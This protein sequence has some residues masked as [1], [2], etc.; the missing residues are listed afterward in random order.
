[1][2]DEFDAYTAEIRHIE[3]E[4]FAGCPAAERL[5]NES[6]WDQNRGRLEQVRE[7]HGIR[8]DDPRI[9]AVYY[10]RRELAAVD[11]EAM[12]AAR[13]ERANPA[14]TP[15]ELE[16]FDHNRARLRRRVADV[17]ARFFGQINLLDLGT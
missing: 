7:A 12:E 14:P 13:A 3:D 5:S 6:P 4:W 16:A 11:A 1:M 9:T 15:A 10:Y 2:N 8:P 17:F